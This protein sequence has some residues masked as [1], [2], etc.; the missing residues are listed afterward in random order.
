MAV[1][2]V[3]W[4]LLHI[5]VLRLLHS[6]MSPPAEHTRPRVP[7]PL[8]IVSWNANS[9]VG[10]RLHDLSDE[11]AWADVIAVQ[12]TRLR[13][14]HIPARKIAAA[15]HTAISWGWAR[16][17]WSNK[18]AG[19]AILLSPRLQASLQQHY[20]PPPKLAGRAGA[21]RLRTNQEDVLIINLYVPPPTS[22]S[23]GTYDGLLDALFQWIQQL[24]AAAPVR[25]MPIVMGDL[26]TGFGEVDYSLDSD[27]V[28]P[29]GWGKRHWTSDTWRTMLGAMHM[30][31]ATTFHDVGPTFWRNGHHSRIDHIAV[32]STARPRIKAMLPLR[33][34]MARLQMSPQEG[35]D[36][37]VPLLLRIDARVILPP[38]REKP[39]RL[40]RDQ[41]M[42]A[43]T[44]G[45]AAR[46]D[47]NDTLQ[48]QVQAIPEEEWTA[49]LLM[50]TPDR[51]WEL[52]SVALKQATDSVF[53]RQDPPPQEAAE[54]PSRRDLLRQRRDL[55]TQLASYAGQGGL[56]GVTRRLQVLEAQLRSLTATV[57]K[58]A[59]QAAQATRDRICLGVQEAWH[60][61]DFA[62][63]HRLRTPLA[64]TGWGPRRRYYP[65]PPSKKIG[66]AEWHDLLPRPGG[67]GG[68]DAAPCSTA[69][70]SDEYN[71]HVAALHD[72]ALPADANMHYQAERDVRNTVAGLINCRKRRA[73]PEW[74]HIPEVLLMALRPSYLSR[75]QVR[76]PV[77]PAPPQHQQRAPLPGPLQAEFARYAAKHPHVRPCLPAAAALAHTGHQGLGFQDHTQPS[78]HTFCERFT[79]LMVRCRCLATLPASWHRCRSVPIDKP[80]STAIGA[81]SSRLI[82]VF[83]GM[84][85]GYFRGLQKDHPP[86]TAHM[87]L[88][89]PAGAQPGR[90]HPQPV[91]LCME[92]TRASV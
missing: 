46:D 6:F 51:A 83:G 92:G 15:A 85:G 65:T 34:Q 24:L 72:T 33:R 54:G 29:V 2:I 8:Q 25:T 78:G 3:H 27:V 18:S 50:P 48:R 9:L 80:G 64:K 86:D 47:F 87:G 39:T 7:R 68:M 40:D 23:R 12:G 19:V 43:L 30:S 36:D 16:T 56:A 52:L 26:N 61:R 13:A 74:S 21:V 42:H 81:R 1:N 77:T 17:A 5:A 71:A 20:S 69:R 76:P 62:M 89:L 66:A 55:R 63:L 60:D 44:M 49:A 11:L 91:D 10:D 45:G 31:I 28:G 32:P 22:V 4:L 41:I 37:H 75:R 14:G 84:T 82:H 57:K 73:A 70:W 67:E 79:Q 35:L 58:Q 38:P 88:R 53:E 90:G 59:K